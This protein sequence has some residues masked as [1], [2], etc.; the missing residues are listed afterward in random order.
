M[1]IE[2]YGCWLNKADS[3]V[4]ASMLEER[5]HLIVESPSEA[6][7]VV[8]NTCAVRSETERK[9]IRRLKH[10]EEWSRGGA[11]RKVVV[12]GC[13]ARVRPALIAYQSPSAS[14][15]GPNALPSLLRALETKVIDVGPDRR[16]PF[17]L[18]RF[19]GVGSR[20]L[21]IPIASGCLGC[22][23][24]CIMPISR[25]KL[26]SSPPQQVKDLLQR[27]ILQGVKEVYLVA[28][29]LASYGRDIGC[30]LPELLKALIEVR[31]EY[32]IRLGM[33]EP[34]TLGAVANEMVKVYSNPT[35]YKYL[36]LPLQ[37]GSNRI[38][39]LM[40]RRY[41]REFF[42]KVVELFRSSL[43]DLYLA[44]D[45]IVGFPTETEEDFEET[46]RTIEKLNP[47]KVHVAR[48]AMRPFTQ[49][50]SMH[51]LSDEVKKKRSKALGELVE[52]ITLKN[53]VRYVGREVEVLLVDMAPRGGLVG[54]MANYR[55]VV[56]ECEPSLMWRKISVIIDEAKPHV[57]M[58]R[59]A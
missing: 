22:C 8:I 57:L 37:S 16:L 17:L 1:Y 2:T 6:D 7:V 48:Y 23:S 19:R 30:S 28:Q 27:G 58:G 49:A 25:G 56:V 36:H 29:D 18:P 13:L 24:Y 5:G 10:F 43:D 40:N 26:S 20:R 3:D 59:P 45:V 54:R 11:D 44:T 32:R 4:A 33:M 41:T 42:F 38:L 21:L 35:I 39:E 51:Q 52:E 53:N 50:S 15:I 34:S 9:I 55:P 46:L 12:M 47:D 31:G 14:I